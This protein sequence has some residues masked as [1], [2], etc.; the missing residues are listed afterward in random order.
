M[1]GF[2]NTLQ[3]VFLQRDRFDLQETDLPSCRGH[4]E[5]TLYDF[6]FRAGPAG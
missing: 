1:A 4:L 2:D 5:Q 6:S 3:R